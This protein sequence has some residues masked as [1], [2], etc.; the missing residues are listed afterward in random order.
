MNVSDLIFNFFAKK[1]VKTVFFVPG[2]GAMFLNDALAR[3]SKIK[4]ISN[5]NEQASTIS[6]EASARINGNIGLAVVTTGPGG[7]NAVTGIAGAWLESVP[8]FVISGQVK[9]DDLKKNSRLR[10]KGPQEVGIVDIVKTI[11]KYAK[12]IENENEILYELE[13][14]YDIATNGR[15]G[16][17]LLDIPLDIQSKKI[18]LSDQKKYSPVKSKDLLKK[19]KKNLFNKL[20]SYLKASERPLFVFGHGVRLSN[21]VDI[22]QK[23]I[24]KYQIPFVTTWN[25]LDIESYDN[26]LNIGRPGSVALRAPNFAVQNSDL[27]ISIGARLDNIVTAFNSKNFAPYAKKIIVD[28]D[29]YELKKHQLSNATMINANCNDFLR[30]L[31]EVNFKI[32]RNPK[33]DEWQDKCKYWKKKYSIN[34]GKKLSRKAPLSHFTVIDCLSNLLPEDSL[35][36]TGSSGL[37]IESFYASFR[38]KPNQR[39]FLTS[40]LGAMGYGI[41]ALLGA[42][43]ESTYK[44]IFC[45]ESDGSFMMNIQEMASLSQIKKNLIIILLNNNGYSSIRNTQK[46]YFNSNYIGID[47]KSGLNIPNLSELAKNFG[48]EVFTLKKFEDIRSNFPKILSKKG[49]IFCEIFLRKDD[50]LW[51][52]VAAIPKNDGKIISMPLEDMTPLLDIKDLEN[53]MI[54]PLNPMSLKARDL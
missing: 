17:V 25:S 49:H 47:K 4:C 30:L 29:R 27:L 54:V 20:I 44:N 38:N 6:A 15:K 3:Q 45:I 37:A 5:H 1:G 32:V 48:F 50:L 23:V 28:I 36:V 43:F 22:V 13:K 31:N 9:R 16:P 46:N 52:K 10:Q 42:S 24:K 2:G 40:A 21:S 12:T 19:N 7:T 35:I 11:T 26:E 39:I 53:E 33:I 51:P 8:L 34:D 14:A 18:L 41:P